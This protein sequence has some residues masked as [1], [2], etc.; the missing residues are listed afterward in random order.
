MHWLI[1]AGLVAVFI[2][3]GRWAGRP[4]RVWKRT[5]RQWQGRDPH[6]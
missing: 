2:A 1:L 6:E 3:A 4:G 5:V